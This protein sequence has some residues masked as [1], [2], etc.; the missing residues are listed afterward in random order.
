MYR[1]SDIIRVEQRLLPRPQNKVFARARRR[2]AKCLDL[3]ASVL[4]ELSVHARSYGRGHGLGTTPEM[5]AK[6]NKTLR[7]Q[8]RNDI[9]KISRRKNRR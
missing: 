3:P 7:R 1:V 5:V 9:A 2:A 8:R 6:A 4:E